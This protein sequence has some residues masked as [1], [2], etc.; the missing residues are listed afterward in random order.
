MLPKLKPR[1]HKCKN[2]CWC[3]A[4]AYA[5]KQPYARVYAMFKKLRGHEGGLEENFVFSYLESVHDFHGLLWDPTETN[6]LRLKDVCKYYNTQECDIVCLV[7]WNEKSSHVVYIHN[8]TFYDVLESGCAFTDYLETP[9]SRMAIK[10][11]G[12]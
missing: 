1:K 2:D 10:Y 7:K 11:R 12:K 3:D 9:V 6:C 8:K 4:V 5:T